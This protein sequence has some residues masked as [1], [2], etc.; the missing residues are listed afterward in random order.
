MKRSAITL[1]LICILSS[2][3][4]AGEIPTVGLK[5]STPNETTPLTSSSAPGEVPTVG[6][7]DGMVNLAPDMIELIISLI[8]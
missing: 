6:Y 4:T 5:D 8:I 3:V 2:L 1:V 7:N